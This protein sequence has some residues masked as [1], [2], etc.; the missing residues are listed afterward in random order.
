[1]VIN[2]ITTHIPKNI[3]QR[4]VFIDK[5]NLPNNTHNDQTPA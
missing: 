3:V 5:K 2:G 4:R 1:M